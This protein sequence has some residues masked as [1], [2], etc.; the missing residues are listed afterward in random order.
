M[1]KKVCVSM[2]WRKIVCED[3]LGVGEDVNYEEN[4]ED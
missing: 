1:R 3:H 4:G 2:K